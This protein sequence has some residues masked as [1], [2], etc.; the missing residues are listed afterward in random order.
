MS[1]PDSTTSREDSG[2][3]RPATP[4]HGEDLADAVEREQSARTP[5]FV[6][7]GV[8]VAIAAAVVIVLALVVLTV[9]LV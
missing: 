7:A 9:Y 4:A 3:P 8:W 2:R 1:N 6:V 5:L